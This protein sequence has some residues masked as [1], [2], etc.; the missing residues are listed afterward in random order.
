MKTEWLREIVRTLMGSRF[1]FDLSI[2]ER[3]NLVLRVLNAMDS[4][5]P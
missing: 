2:R 1:Y 5:T 3:Y 4:P